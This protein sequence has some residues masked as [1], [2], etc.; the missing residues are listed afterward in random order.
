MRDSANQQNCSRLELTGYLQE[1]LLRDADATT[2]AQGLELRV[3]FL[4]QIVVD[5]ALRIPEHIHQM[6]GN[7]T[8]LRR[9]A[10]PVLP[11]AVLRA[12]KQGFNLALAPWLQMNTRFRPRRI[13]SL[14]QKNLERHGLRIPQ[15]NIARS[16][17]LLKLT[18]KIAPYWR[19]VVLAE[20]LQMVKP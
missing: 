3:P 1:T 8:L 19:W 14:L 10:E 4:D 11:T 5:L 7:K 12:P 18:G 2:M 20:W 15:E 16:W 13:N 6:E 17:I 9:L